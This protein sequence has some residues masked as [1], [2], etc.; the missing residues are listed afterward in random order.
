[1]LIYSKKSIFWRKANKVNRIS[2]TGLKSKSKVKIKNQNQ[3]RDTFTLKGVSLKLLDKFTYHG[4]SE[5][6]TKSDINT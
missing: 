1:M 2:L 5:S 3:R 4:S 6:S